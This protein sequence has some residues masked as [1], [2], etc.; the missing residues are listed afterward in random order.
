VRAYL[1]GGD[2]ESSNVSVDNE[3]CTFVVDELPETGPYVLTVKRPGP[4]ERVPV[5]SP[6]SGDPPPLCV[7]PP[8][9]EPPA[10]LLVYV[11]D[12]GGL[13][14]E[15][16]ELEWTLEGD[17]RRGEIGST[18]VQGSALLNGR[19]PGQTLHL[20]VTAADER[21]VDTTV[22][23]G[24]SVTEAVLTLPGR[25]KREDGEARVETVV[26]E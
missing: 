25:E 12:P 6:L 10:S 11:A 18:T 5:T 17:A 22:V 14:A 1:R 13:L 4:I 15:P 7:F 19:R 3:T 9:G 8:C 16:A 26:V 20:R 2:G 24:S 21:A 23:V